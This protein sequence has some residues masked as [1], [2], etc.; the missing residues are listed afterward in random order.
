[1]ALHLAV[2]HGGAPQRPLQVLHE[3][4]RRALRRHSRHLAD[5]VVQVFGHPRRGLQALG[6]LGPKRECVCV[7]VWWGAEVPGWGAAL[8]PKVEAVARALGRLVLPQVRGRM[9]KER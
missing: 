2:L 6:D 4:A 3:G 9:R 5:P 1:M 8:G 7:C